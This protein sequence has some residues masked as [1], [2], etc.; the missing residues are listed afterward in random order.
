MAS[1]SGLYIGFTLL[2]D[3]VFASMVFSSKI[4]Y[5]RYLITNTSD[6]PV[7]FS[8]FLNVRLSKKI[9]P[10]KMSNICIRVKD[11]GWHRSHFED[12]SN[13]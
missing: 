10:I 2:L 1:N 6:L 11:Y 5:C 8:L 3:P 4:L 13:F 12:K 7:G 9:T